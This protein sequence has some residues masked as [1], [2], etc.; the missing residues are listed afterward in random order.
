MVLNGMVLPPWC[1][2]ADCSNVVEPYGF[3]TVVY[4]GG[5]VRVLNLMH[6]ATIMSSFGMW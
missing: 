6:N 1:T 3:A 4:S 5:L 2:L